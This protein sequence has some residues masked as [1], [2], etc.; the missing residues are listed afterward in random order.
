MNTWKTLLIAVAVAVTV[1]TNSVEAQN[2]VPSCAQQLIP[3]VN[4]IN[5]TTT[6]PTSCCDPIKQTVQTQLP[7]LC[8]LYTTPGLLESFGI[9]VTQA[10]DLSRRCGVHTDLSQCKG[11][12]PSPSSGTE[13]PPAT[14]GGGKSGA[15]R[16]A[17]TGLSFLFLFW[18]TLLF[19]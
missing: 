18:A 19:N 10:V 8:N 7:C 3:C 11:S 13:T 17:F 4:Y 2:G 12:A 1:A 6:P 16:V 5:S 15:G 9:N 14:P